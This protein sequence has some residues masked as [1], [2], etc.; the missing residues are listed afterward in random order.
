MVVEVTVDECGI[1]IN[2]RAL[3]A[4]GSE[5][6]KSAAVSAALKWRFTRT[7]LDGR[8]VKVIGPIT[9]NFK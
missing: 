1:V 3:S 2:A 5:E 8:P 4:S 9:F 7:K 6:L